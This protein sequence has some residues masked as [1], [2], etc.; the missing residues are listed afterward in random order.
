MGEESFMERVVKNAGLA[1]LESFFGQ[2]FLAVRQMVLPPQPPQPKVID[3]QPQPK[4]ELP[5]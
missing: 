3:V 2:C 4:Y 5:K 1:M